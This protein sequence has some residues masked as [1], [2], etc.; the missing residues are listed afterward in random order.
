MKEVIFVK[1]KLFVASCFAAAAVGGMIGGVMVWTY[2]IINANRK[3][4]NRLHEILDE[5]SASL[6][7]VIG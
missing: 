6:D 3:D 2:T 5:A 1:G 7:K 4:R